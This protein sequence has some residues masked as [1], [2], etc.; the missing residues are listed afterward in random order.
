LPGASGANASNADLWKYLQEAFVTYKAPVGRG[1]LFQLG[2]CL[3]PI[4]YESLAVKENWNWSRSNL[5][6]ALPAYHAGLRVTYP[7]TDELSATVSVFNGW[8]SVVD[9]NEEKSLEGD[10]IYE[11][12]DRIF[13]Q[14]LYFGGVERSAGSPEGAPW[15]HHFD[16]V[17]EYAVTKWLSLAGQADY[18]WESN[19]IGKA[20][21]IAGALYGRVQPMER[22]YV[23]LRGDRFH[24]HLAT[25]NGASSTPLF[26]GGAAWVWSATVTLDVRLHDQLS[27]RLEYR[28]DAANAPLYFRGSVEGDGALTPYIANATTQDTVLLG[29]TAWF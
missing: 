25:G 13:L 4:G 17:G 28:H 7:F 16:G 8:N 21:W 23:A 14:A 18:G 20:D 24:E 1:L 27:I 3:S 26:W 29:A 22:V 2:L 10:V 15:R 12:K 5:F 9:N 6:F 11:V 19:Q